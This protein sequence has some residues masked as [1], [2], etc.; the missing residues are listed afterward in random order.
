VI[1]HPYEW[2]TLVRDCKFTV[3]NMKRQMFLDFESYSKCCFIQNF[4]VEGTTTE[5]V[6]WKEIRALKYT[7]G[8]GIN[9]IKLNHNDETTIKVNRNKKKKI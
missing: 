8:F 9:D 4:R 2:R 3:V 1:A 6:Q 5:K 7:K